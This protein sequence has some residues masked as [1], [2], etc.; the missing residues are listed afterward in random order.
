MR[1][2][3]CLSQSL[4]LCTYHSPERACLVALTAGAERLGAHRLHTSQCRVQVRADTD[5]VTGDLALWVVCS[6]RERTAHRQ[7]GLGE[8]VGCS[9]MVKRLWGFHSVTTLAATGRGA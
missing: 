9:H 8:I 7:R 5:I 3:D 1:Q 4:H 2:Y 6:T